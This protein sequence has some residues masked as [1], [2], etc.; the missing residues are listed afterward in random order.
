MT[1]IKRRKL[2]LLASHYEPSYMKPSE[3]LSNLGFAYLLRGK[4]TDCEEAF[5]IFNNIKNNKPF[6]RAFGL[7]L[8]YSQ[9]NKYN[10]A[11]IA[12][13]EA[14]K[15]NSSDEAAWNSKGNALYSLREI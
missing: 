14:T 12:F 2:A 1:W 8:V 11:L 6:D 5:Y 15:L 7:G 4:Y 10:D 9:R 13:S 3:L